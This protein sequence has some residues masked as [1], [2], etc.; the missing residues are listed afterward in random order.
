MNP[1]DRSPRADHLRLVEAL[2]FASAAPLDEDEPRASA[3][4]RA[5]TSRRSSPNSRSTIAA[6]ASISC[7][8]PTAGPCAPRP[9]SPP[10]LKLER[11]VARKLSRAAVETLAIIAYHQPVTRAEIEEIRGVIIS[12]GTLDTL[13]EA[14]WIAPKGRRADRRAGR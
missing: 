7:A 6:A 4:R 5:P 10:R 12:K 13:M 1:D 11:K 3:C 14:G 9:I 8:S 2:L